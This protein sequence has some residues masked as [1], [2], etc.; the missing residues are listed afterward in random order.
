MRA[1]RKAQATSRFD[2]GRFLKQLFDAYGYLA[3]I[4]QPGWRPGQAGPG[5]V[6]ALNDVH[7][8]LTVLPAAAAII[9]G[10][11]SPATYCGWTVRRIPGP[12]TAIASPFRPRRAARDAT[13]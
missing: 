12:M 7:A 4:A 5:P 6:V 10:T 1:L 8:L 2:A 3:K 13:A 9:R 11:S